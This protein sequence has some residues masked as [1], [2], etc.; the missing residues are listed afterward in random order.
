MV[1]FVNSQN[2]LKSHFFFFWSSSKRDSILR[3]CS[4]PNI[5][6]NEELPCL[7]NY[8]NQGYD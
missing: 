2:Y 4:T 1:I 7:E 6:D 5:L 3:V 8:I